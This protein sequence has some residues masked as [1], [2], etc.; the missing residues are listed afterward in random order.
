MGEKTGL[1]PHLKYP[2][3]TEEDDGLIS[4][5]GNQ[6]SGL[7][8]NSSLNAPNDCYMMKDSDGLTR[9]NSPGMPYIARHVSYSSLDL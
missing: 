5:R 3:H 8:M 2:G 9:K 4:N 1:V 7:P 6:G